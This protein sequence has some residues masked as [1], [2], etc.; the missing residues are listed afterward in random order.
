MRPGMELC[1]HR[2]MIAADQTAGWIHQPG[3]GAAA[4]VEIRRR[5]VMPGTGARR[6]GK[7]GAWPL[8]LEFIG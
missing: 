8:P 6:A 7:D 1:L 4:V 5:K 3:I 2:D